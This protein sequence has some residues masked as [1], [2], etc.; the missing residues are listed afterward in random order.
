MARGSARDDD[1]DDDDIVAPKKSKLLLIVVALLVLVLA[2]GGGFAYWFFAVHSKTNAAPV[3]VPPVYSKLDVF[4]VNLKDPGVALQTAITLRVANDDVSA[5]VTLRMP[6]IRNQV[7]LLL[8]NQKSADLMTEGG[9]EKLGMDIEAAVN[10]ILKAKT[11]KDG[12]DK[13]L[14]TSFIIQ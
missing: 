9:K 1:D 7:L 8:S 4:T 2:G 13:V 11:P 10:K 12:V 6:E 5:D 14:F 3:D